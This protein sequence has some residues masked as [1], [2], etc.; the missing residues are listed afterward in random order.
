[1]GILVSSRGYG[2]EMDD[3]GKTRGLVP[4]ADMFNHDTDK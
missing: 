4:F 1:M 3:I 2:L